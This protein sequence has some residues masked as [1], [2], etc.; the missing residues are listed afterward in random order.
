MRTGARIILA[1]AGG[2]AVAA[3]FWRRRQRGQELAGPG[4]PSSTY[5]PT[6]AVPAVASTSET[7]VSPA[8]ASRPSAAP[9][10]AQ[11][12]PQPGDAAAAAAAAGPAASPP[13]AAGRRTLAELRAAFPTLGS[14]DADAVPAAALLQGGDAM[15][16]GERYL[17]L[18]HPGDALLT[19]RTY[20][21]QVPAGHVYLAQS[22][23]AEAVFSR[24]ARPES[25]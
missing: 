15:E 3:F 4:A 9:E 11:G 12:A 14:L 6:A 13:A 20:R 24:L 22:R 18:C 7:G 17:D 10:E 1:A 21:E 5:V 8:A 19:P 2:L 25:R 16:G 23:V